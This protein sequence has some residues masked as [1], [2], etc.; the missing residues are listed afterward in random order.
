MSRKFFTH[1]TPTLF[2]AG[3]PKPQMSSC[4]LLKMQNDSIEGIYDT[5]KQC[6]SISK[7]AGGI[8]VA[9]S[10]VRASGSYIRGTNGHSNGLVPMLRN[11]NETARHGRATALHRQRGQLAG[12]THSALKADGL[13]S[14][15]LRKLP[16]TGMWIRAVARGRALSPCTW[17][18]GMRMAPAGWKLFRWPFVANK[19]KK[20]VLKVT[21]AWSCLK[22]NRCTRVAK[23]RPAHEWYCQWYDR[24]ILE[25]VRARHRESF[26]EAKTLDHGMDPELLRQLYVNADLAMGGDGQLP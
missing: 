11:F 6:A 8:G 7:S 19:K 1:A 13:K 22:C 24:S 4:F 12:G 20:R 3:T 2:N 21:Q 14:R 25:G 5:L 16:A 10:N 23:L 15:N 9:I 18:P 26:E 17:S